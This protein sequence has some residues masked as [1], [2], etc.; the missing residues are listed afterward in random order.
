MLVELGEAARER[1]ALGVGER[2]RTRAR[3]GVDALPQW[4]AARQEPGG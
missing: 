4:D 3:N 2:R 1:F